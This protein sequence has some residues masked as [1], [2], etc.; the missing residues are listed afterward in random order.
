MSYTFR[1]HSVEIIVADD[2]SEASAHE[3]VNRDGRKV[4]GKRLEQFKRTDKQSAEVAAI[5]WAK[6]RRMK[7]LAAESAEQ[8]AS[9]PATE[10]NK[11]KK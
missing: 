1:L 9:P 8:P 6:S 5:Q 10:T 3:I 11:R 4:T 7:Q 2:G